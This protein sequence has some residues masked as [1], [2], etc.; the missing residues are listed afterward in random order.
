MNNKI[1]PHEKAKKFWERQR[2]KKEKMGLRV[3]AALFV[4][5]TIA[6]FVNSLVAKVSLVILT[7]L[8]I[9]WGWIEE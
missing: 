3:A 5:L 6:A 7:L 4:F 1:N 8:L 2:K 9:Y